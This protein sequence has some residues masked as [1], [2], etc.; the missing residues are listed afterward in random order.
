MLP[1]EV[2]DLFF[3]RFKNL[4]QIKGYTLFVFCMLLVG[5]GISISMPYLSLYCTGV[6]GMSAGAFGAIIATSSLSGVVVN[7]LIAKRSDNGL[8]RKKLIILAMVSSCFGYASYLVFHSFITLLIVIMVFNGLGA[9]AMPQIYAYAQESINDSGSE[10][11][12]FATS[13]LRS[14]FSLGFVLGPLGGTLILGVLGYKGLFIS[15]SLIYIIIAS[16]VLIFLKKREF[17][18]KTKP[19]FKD[20]TALKNPQILQPLI[21]FVFLL[22]LNAMNGLNTP[23]FIVNKLNGTHSDVGFVVSISAF[24]E[25]PVMLGLG[26]LGK[27][28]SNHFLL[29]LG[30]FIAVLYYIILSVS[31]ASWQIICAQLLQA[32]FV[33]IVMGNGLSYFSEF[34]PHSPGVAVTLYSNGSTIGRLIGNLGGGM[35]ATY[36]GYR[37]VYWVCLVFAVVAFLILWRTNPRSEQNHAT[38]QK[39]SV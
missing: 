35:M 22:A 23:L 12:R 37:Q 36:I 29:M 14:L 31:T 2:T 39:Q 34:L 8:D 15:T 1:K 4:F 11:T 10:E 30:S 16:L 28:I 19:K 17:Q 38:L 33:A 9:L 6:I 13:T 18:G 26:S 3:S 5:M 24:L 25:I 27:K 20:K 7:S 21:A 32:I